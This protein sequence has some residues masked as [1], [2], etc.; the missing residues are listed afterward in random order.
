MGGPT[1][2]KGCLKDFFGAIGDG[3]GPLPAKKGAR[4]KRAAAPV[5]PGAV[6]PLATAGIRELLRP[7][8]PTEKKAF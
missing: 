2:V 6:A 1:V 8:Q 4:P 3:D 5:V 7:P